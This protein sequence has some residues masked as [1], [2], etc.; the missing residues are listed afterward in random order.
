MNFLGMPCSQSSS[1]NVDLLNVMTDILPATTDLRD[2]GSGA[3]RWRDGTFKQMTSDKFINPTAPGSNVLLA[4]GNTLAI[5]GSPATYQDVYTNSVFPA[6]ATTNI[7]GQDIKFEDPLSNPVMYISGST[8]RVGITDLTGGT[9]NPINVHEDIDM[10]VNDISNAGTVTANALVK[11]G[12]NSNQYLIADGSVLTQSAVS[13]NANFYLYSFD[14]VT[15]GPPIIS[16]TVSCDNATMSSATIVWLSLTT[17]DSISI[18]RFVQ[19]ITLLNDFY[20]QDKASAVNFIQYNITA[21]PTIFGTYIQIPVISASAG[22]T[23]NTNFGVIPVVCSFFVN[24]L[25]VDTRLS[26]LETKTQNM[27]AVAGSTKLSTI[28]TTN[29]IQSISATPMLIGTTIQTGMTIGQVAAPMVLNASSTLV[30][31]SINCPSIVASVFDS[32]GVAPLN[33]GITNASSIAIGKAGTVTTITGTSTNV[34]S[35]LNVLGT[36][37]STVAGNIKLNSF[38]THNT[39]IQNNIQN[40]SAGALASSDWVATNNLGDDVNGFV[41]VGINSSGFAAGGIGGPSDAYVYSVEDTATNG[42][43]LWVGTPSN[44]SV[45]LFSNTAAPTAFNSIGVTNAVMTVPNSLLTPLI[46]APSAVSLNIGTAT[47]TAL[48]MGYG[49]V[50]TTINGLTTT[51]GTSLISP[52]VK[53]PNITT[54]TAVPL[55]IG[56][57]TQTNLTLGRATVANTLVTGLNIAYGVVPYLGTI[58]NPTASNSRINL[59]KFLRTQDLANGLSGTNNLAATG[60]GSSLATA[61]NEQ[62]VGSTWRINVAGTVSATVGSTLSL[63]VVHAGGTQTIFT[64]TYTAISSFT[65]WDGNFNIGFQT[66]G[67]SVPAVYTGVIRYM[68]AGIYKSEPI[69]QSFS[70]A[71]NTTVANTNVFNIVSSAGTYT[72][73]YF[74]VEYLR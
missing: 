13:G 64:W 21:A 1:S 34:S 55:L 50:A 32:I 46:N 66:I 25:E 11:T 24:G 60:Y 23:G 45:Y 71:Y 58:A 12:G 7:Y 10:L 62:I 42:G 8:G 47:H 38:D 67:V 30:S 37:A 54:N 31:T 39:F 17:S 35:R 49:A 2:I 72:I 3:K 69:R 5:G 40:L 28:L 63:Q 43:N 33:I 61:A 68:D 74:N 20:I 4:N 41:D 16:G 15:T 52:L 56:T 59:V 65:S 14:P 6:S 27:T 57:T 22:G 18:E 73:S 53:T 9:G 51:I 19:Q 36:G 29:T 48:T 70:P 44:K 26:A